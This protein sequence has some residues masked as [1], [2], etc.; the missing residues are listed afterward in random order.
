[1]RMMLERRTVI[2]LGVG[3]A[4][5]RATALMCAERLPAHCHR[6]LIAD[7]IVAHGGAV[8]HLLDAGAAEE[9][10]LHPAAR[11]RDGQ[12]FYDGDTQG[13]LGL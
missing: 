13:E 10:R 2:V 12:L 4:M 11:L 1:M 8:T 3:P 6:F 7:W 9:H 5:G